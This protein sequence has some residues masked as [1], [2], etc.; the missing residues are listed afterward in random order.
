MTPTQ[1]GSAFTAVLRSSGR[2]GAVATALFTAASTPASIFSIAAFNSAGVVKVAAAML[3][4]P[5]P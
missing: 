4:E 2:P 1:A 3:F 5:A